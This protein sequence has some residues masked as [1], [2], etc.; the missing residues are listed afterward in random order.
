MPFYAVID[1]NVLVS[2]L[3]SRNS[4]SSPVQIAELIF[5][6][7]IIPLY[8]AEIIAEYSEVLRRPKFHFSPE[9]IETMLKAILQLGEN[10][11]PLATGMILADKKDLVFYEVTMSRPRGQCTFGDRKQKTFSI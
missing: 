11:E 3:L 2:A 4:D 10:V 1:T 7:E 8:S 5:S 6:G 9:H